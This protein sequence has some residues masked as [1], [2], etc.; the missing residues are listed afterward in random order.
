LAV[1]YVY[2]VYLIYATLA[3][4]KAHDRAPR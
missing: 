1:C 4:N 2:D 3:H